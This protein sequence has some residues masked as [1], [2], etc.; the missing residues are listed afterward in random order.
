MNTYQ[1]LFSRKRLMLCAII[2]AAG[3]NNA[4]ESSLI[5][6]DVSASS[7]SVLFDQLVGTWENENGK[8][9]EQWTKNPDGTF[10]SKV[11][12]VKGTDTCY[13]EEG[14]V[15]KENENWVFENRV[16]NQNDGK[17]VKFTSTQLSNLSVQFS[18]PAHD[19]PTDV[20]YTVV[21]SVTIRAFIIG[22][23]VN[24]KDTF[25]FNYHKVK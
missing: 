24:G 12:S 2:L 23:A 13:N 22:P 9:F 18:N 16:K 4:G 6:K 3:C 10:N 11:F 19:F 25:Y 17:A 5:E 1:F 20:N 21:D 8:S 7:S 15:Y 14:I